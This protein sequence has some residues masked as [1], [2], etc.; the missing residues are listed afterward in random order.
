MKDVKVEYQK[1]NVTLLDGIFKESQEVGKGFL[2]TLDVDRLVASC[3]QAISKIPKK[4]LYGGWEKRGI[5]GHSIG[6]W[7]SA[8]SSMYAVTKDKELKEK[9]DYAIN[10]LEHVQSFDPDGYVSGFKRDCFDKVFAGGDFQVSNFSLGDSWVP[11]YSIHKIY[12]GLID[13]YKLTGNEKALQVVLKLADWAKRG[14]DNLSNQEFQRMLICEHGGMNEAMADLYLITGNTDYLELAIRFCHKAIL[15]PLSKGIDELEGKHANTQIPK[16]VGAAKLFEI[17]GET[18]YHDCAIYFWDIVTRNRSYVIGGNSK[19]EHFGLENTEELG[20]QTNE[21]CNTYNMLKLTEHLFKWTHKVE[22]MDYY[23]RALYNH[24]LASQDPDTGMKTY[25]VS[26]QPGHFKVYCSHDDSFWCCTGTGMENPARYTRQIYHYEN[27]EIYVNLFISSEIEFEKIKLKQETTFPDNPSSKLIF[28]EANNEFLTIHIRVPIWI[29]GELSAK[30]ND[31]HTYSSSENGYLTITGNWNSG[32]VIELSL[33]MELHSYVSKSDSSKV[34]FMYGPIALAGAL[35]RENFPETDILDDHLSLNNYPLI[36]VPT[37]VTNETNINKWI[38][39]V[40]GS[41]LTFETDKIGQPGNKKVTLIPFFALHHQRY[42]L[43]WD[44]MNEEAYKEFLNREQ[45][46][47]GKLQLLTVDQVQ[48]HEQQSEIEHSIKTENSNSGYL[49]VVHR[50][51]RDSRDDGFFS[52]EMAVDPTKRTYL[53]VTYFSGDGILYLDGKTYVRY[54]Q[55]LVNDKEIG[56]QKLEGKV[57]EELFN[58]FYE[59]PTEIT[60][61][62]EKVEVKFVSTKGKIAGGVYGLRTLNGI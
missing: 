50:A 14:T 61:G 51:W 60:R 46:E 10:E 37:L 34:S 41:S 53:C 47:Q 38:N 32:D 36:D 29:S 43:Y 30:V 54:F 57:S 55:I 5:S 9:L 35:G 26:T 20:I 7:L 18:Y 33:P 62:K 42:T 56:E 28:E 44:L 13:T 22:Y 6:H 24:I 52:Y 27:E 11:W 4:P 48:P 8:A 1:Q 40:E 19:N 16:V 3:Y 45:S 39:P 21:T 31:Q 2:L 49:N 17:T 59:I 25:F 23:E 15:D 58:E 12:A